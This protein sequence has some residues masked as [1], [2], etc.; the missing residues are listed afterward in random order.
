MNDENLDALFAQAR[1]RR[2]DTSAAEFAFETRLLAR[3]RARQEASSVWAKAAWRLIPVFAA[4]VIGL[5]V[6][7]V[8]LSNEANDAVAVSNLENPGALDLWNN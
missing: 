2:P 5:T 8:E 6:W 3:L 7:Q 4:C 1:A